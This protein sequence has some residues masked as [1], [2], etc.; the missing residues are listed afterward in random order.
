MRIAQIV[1]SNFKFYRE[2]NL[3]INQKNVLF[4]GENGTGKSSLYWALYM[5]YKVSYSSNIGKYISNLNA[6]HPNNLVNHN[7]QA[8]E[9]SVK[10][11]DEQCNE[12]QIS[13]TK[14]SISERLKD[15]EKTI[16]FLNHEKLSKLFD[17]K[18]DSSYN[19]FDNLK[20][21]FISEYIIFEKLHSSLNKIANKEIEIIDDRVGSESYELNKELSSVLKKLERFMNW[22]LHTRFKEKLSI[23]FY[24]RDEFRFDQKASG[25]W[26]LQNPI[27][28]IKL[29]QYTDFTLRFNEARV[30][31]VSILFYLSLI[32]Y[33]EKK[34]KHKQALRLLVLDD[35]LLSLDMGFRSNVIDFVFDKFLHKYQLFILTHDQIF[36]NLLKRKISH[37]KKSEE[38]I[39]KYMYFHESLCGQYE[40]PEMYSHN[41]DY[42]KKAEDFLSSGNLE[43][44]GNNLRKEMEKIIF[45]MKIKFELGNIGT[46]YNAI[47][48]FQNN[49]NPFLYKH[50]H[51]VINNFQNGDSVKRIL[52]STTLDNETKS[53]K[54]KNLLNT[55]G[56]RISTVALHKILHNLQWHRDIVGNQTSHANS[57]NL[58]NTEFKQAIRDIKELKKL[59]CV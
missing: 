46:L 43:E 44:C 13:A 15:S 39:F 1:L 2:Q 14:N 22:F 54:I 33:N 37:Y 21:D 38:W 3:E 11:I 59:V 19:L 7:T 20:N 32:L 34:T 48:V 55:S 58:Y 29:N 51:D 17:K 4:Y 5:L 30:K 31:L 28:D 26:E 24:I 52:E 47:E 16:H 27:I 25:D 9:A 40:E 50:P 42:L 10:I 35:F 8:S 53:K 6:S 18:V 41:D 56:E 36:F 12:T 23:Q 45:D 57:S 49:H